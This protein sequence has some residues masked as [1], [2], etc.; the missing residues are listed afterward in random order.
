MA[1]WRQSRRQLLIPVVNG[2]VV[3]EFGLPRCLAKELLVS[4]VTVGCARLG[5]PRD[6]RAMFSV[7]CEICRRATADTVM[8]SDVLRCPSAVIDRGSH[9]HVLCREKSCRG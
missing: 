3:A 8:A 7:G 4:T 2:S 6:A 5:E 1:E 9:R